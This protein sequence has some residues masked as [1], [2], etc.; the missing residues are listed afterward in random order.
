VFDF[1]SVLSRGQT[2]NHEFVL[3]N[4]TDRTIK[5]LKA[6]ALT[7]CCSAVGPLPPSIPPGGEVKVPTVLSLG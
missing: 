2:L 1:G 6:E 5:L 4:P 3:R 7:P